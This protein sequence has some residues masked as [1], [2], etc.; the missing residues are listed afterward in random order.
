MKK[1]DVLIVGAG[2]FGATL[3]H[4]LSRQ[5]KK[6]LVVEKRSEIGG[7]CFTKEYKGITVH[8]YGAHIFHTSNPGVWDFVQKF[9]KF[10]SFRNE[11]LAK[12]DGEVFNLPFNMN[13]FSRI[14]K[15]SSPEIVQSLIRKEL[16]KYNVE[17]PKNLEESAINMV[18]LTIYEKFIKGYTEKQWGKSCKNLPSETIKRIPLRFMYN[19]NYFDDVFQ[20][21]P[22]DG[23]TKILERLLESSEV[24]LD[25]D[26]LLQKKS[27]KYA[28]DCVVYTGMIDAYF[29]FEFGELEYRS[30]SFKMKYFENIDNFQGNA[31]VNFPEMRVPYTRCIEHKHFLPEKKIKGT[32]CSYEYS[33]PYSNGAGNIPFYPIRDN[34]NLSLYEKYK[35]LSLSEKNV[36]FCGR[37]GQ[38]KYFDMDDTILEAFSISKKFL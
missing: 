24:V 35:Q 33:F 37:L 19:N 12:I 27:E 11:P 38:Y 30:L 18:G 29:D 23:Y 26:F 4:I 6:V 25:Y 8:K 31:V 36:L 22:I 21:I 9:S 34:W 14:F 1:Y 10:N 28:S 17:N 5:G 15:E 16:E 2:L 20:G 3:A 13:L 7:N 32:V